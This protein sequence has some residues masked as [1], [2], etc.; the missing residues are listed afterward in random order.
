VA[1]VESRVVQADFAGGSTVG[2]ARYLIPDNAVYT[3]NNMLAGEDGSVFAR[4]GVET[5]SVNRA[6][7][8]G[9]FL[10]QGLLGAQVRTLVADDESFYV[11]DEDGVT[12][13]DIGG[14][15]LDRPRVAAE[16]SGYLFIGE[17]W[18]YGGSRKAP[19][20]VGSVTVT[21]G[22]KTVGVANADTIIDAGMIFNVGQARVYRVESVTSS[23]VVLSDPYEGTS[24]TYTGYFY[25]IYK[26][27]ASDPYPISFWYATTQNRMFAT[28]GFKS[29]VVKMSKLNSPL[30]PLANPHVWLENDNHEVSDGG[31]VIGCRSIGALLLVFATNGLWVLTGSGQ[32]I[33]NETTGAPQHTFTALDRSLILKELVG[34]ASWE[35]ML[36]VPAMDGAFL[37]DGISTPRKI[38]HA[39]EE[40]WMR[41]MKGR[42]LGIAATYANYYILP[43]FKGTDTRADDP[44]TII[45]RLDLAAQDG[46]RTARFGWSWFT[47]SGSKMAAYVHGHITGHH[48]QAI[49][50]HHLISLERLRDTSDGAAVCDCSHV[51]ESH[52]PDNGYDQDGSI[53]IP[54]LITRDME[55]GGLTENVIRKLRLAREHESVADATVD[56][57]ARALL[58]FATGTVQLDSPYWGHLDG[59]WGAGFG[60]P[61]EGIVGDQP[62]TSG[63]I[64]R[65]Y[66]VND[67]NG[68]PETSPPD[69]GRYPFDFR[70][71]RRG[72]GTS[73]RR[74]YGRF[75]IW[76]DRPAAKWVIQRI[77]MH[78][79]PAGSTRR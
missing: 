77:E 52:H 67:R 8:K 68:S 32:Q 59:Q 22:Q 4:G 60:P 45:C 49:G 50:G 9:Q 40:P 66:P 5:L 48:D 1:A 11:L 51:Y 38:S 53:F 63:D 13:V 34:I 3:L 15:G 75:R 25:G 62:W 18:I 74:Y 58:G 21:T 12:L 7:S 23:T 27:T 20:T 69:D 37:V 10:W 64:D 57:E 61:K 2:D 24:G 65:W 30:P 29:N 42:E 54:A 6:T 70:L 79:R 71:G 56:E 28:E 55:T 36:V 47:G 14:T 46:R 73:L 35:N 31:E 78:S 44:A 19:Q 43:L 72:V 33:V 41:E 16:L 26:I 76:S 17:G 39:I